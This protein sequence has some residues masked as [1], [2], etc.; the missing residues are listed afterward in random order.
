MGKAL[1]GS[2]ESLASVV[3]LSFQVVIALGSPCRFVILHYRNLRIL[4][5]ISVI[6]NY[7]LHSRWHRERFSYVL[8]VRNYVMICYVRQN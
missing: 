3:G 1:Q 2:I 5:L 7:Y 4:L 6:N 8:H